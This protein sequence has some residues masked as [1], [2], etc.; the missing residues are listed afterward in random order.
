MAAKRGITPIIAIILL[1]MMTVAAGGTLFYWLSRIQHQEQGTVESSQAQLFETLSSCVSIP[2]FRY[3]TIDNQTDVVFQNCGN[4]LH[5]IG[6]TNLIEDRVI[7]SA[8]KACSFLL[9][10]TNCIGC[11]FDLEPGAVQNVVLNF[12]AVGACN[13]NIKGNIKSEISFFIDRKTSVSRTF[14]PE[15]E[16]V[17]DIKTANLTA[18]TQTGLGTDTNTSFNISLTNSGNAL[19]TLIY[20]AVTTVPSGATCGPIRLHENLTSAPVYLNAS[21]VSPG[22]NAT[23]VIVAQ[24]S[25]TG[26]RS[27]NST[28]TIRSN[29]CNS[30]S[31]QI[32]VSAVTA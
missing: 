5:R 2:T 26:A 3:N 11:P 17:C 16:V 23:L 20:A 32:I 10:N 30:I 7:V 18:L 22:S 25:N 21:Q 14:V 8:G 4:V 19:D 29:N 6:D 13:A 12:T 24:A 1:L 9:N 28:I 27:C 15:D 31:G